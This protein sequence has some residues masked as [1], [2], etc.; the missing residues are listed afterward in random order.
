MPKSI[1]QFEKEDFLLSGN[2]SLGN[3]PI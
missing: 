1:P 3:P 2:T